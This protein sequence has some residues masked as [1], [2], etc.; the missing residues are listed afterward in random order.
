MAIKDIC[1]LDIHSIA[2]TS[3]ALFMWA[4]MPTL[5]SAF[6]VMRCWGFR[7]VGVAFTWVKTSKK[8]LPVFGTGQ[9]TRSN[10]ELCLLGLKGS[11][12]QNT[13][14]RHDIGQVVLSPRRLHSQKPDE[15]YG[16][17]EDLFGKL[18][19]VELFARQS[20]EGWDRIIGDYDETIGS[21]PVQTIYWRCDTCGFETEMEVTEYAK[22]ACPRCFHETSFK[23]EQHES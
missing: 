23:E 21:V 1:A 3:C 17:I 2:D 6:E 19:R 5:P 4:T 20:V 8:M 7:Y 18:P 22:W 9:Y 14:K 16:L 15:I 11:G 13:V 10:A 12:W